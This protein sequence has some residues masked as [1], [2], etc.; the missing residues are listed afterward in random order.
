MRQENEV[1]CK[2]FFNDFTGPNGLLTIYAVEDFT[3]NFPSL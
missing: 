1:S 3:I 2:I